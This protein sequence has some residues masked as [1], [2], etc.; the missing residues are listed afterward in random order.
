[1]LKGILNSIFKA[2]RSCYRKSHSRLS[3]PEEEPYHSWAGAHI[4]SGG[5]RQSYTQNTDHRQ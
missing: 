4:D 2:N 3:S 1:M 5:V